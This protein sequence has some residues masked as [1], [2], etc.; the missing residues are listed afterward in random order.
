MPLPVWKRSGVAYNV[1]DVVTLYPYEPVRPHGLGQYY[2]N[3]LPK[4]HSCATSFG[5]TAV[6][7]PRSR[8]RRPSNSA[9]TENLRFSPVKLSNSRPKNAPS[10]TRNPSASSTPTPSNGSL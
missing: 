8:S 7:T 5:P 1:G 3:P 10:S 2:S 9:R 4:D 6:I